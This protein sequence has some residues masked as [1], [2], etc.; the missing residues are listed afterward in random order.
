MCTSIKVATQDTLY[1]KRRF[2]WQLLLQFYRRDKNLCWVRLYVVLGQAWCH[3]VLGQ[4]RCLRQRTTVMV[5][6]PCM[7]ACMQTSIPKAVYADKHTSIH[8]YLQTSIHASKHLYIH[9]TSSEKPNLGVVRLIL[10][11][12]CSIPSNFICVLDQRWVGGDLSTGGPR[13]LG[14]GLEHLG[15]TNDG[16]ANQ[17]AVGDHVLLG[18]EHLA[19]KGA[20]LGWT[21]GLRAF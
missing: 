15:G 5:V 19:G 2:I 9:M 6:H 13:V 4:A 10:L 21:C 1:Q 20:G 16:L 3:V 14:H 8:A 7:Q 12:K 11:H 18:D 17:I